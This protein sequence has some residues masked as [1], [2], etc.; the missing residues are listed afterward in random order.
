MKPETPKELLNRKVQEFRDRNE[1]L[2]AISD[3][4]EPTND[5]RYVIPAKFIEA[6]RKLL[7][8]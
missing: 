1:L 3:S 7:A 8:A 4:A 5:G 2:Q 6:V